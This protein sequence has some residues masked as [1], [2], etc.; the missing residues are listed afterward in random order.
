[1][2]PRGTVLPANRQAQGRVVTAQKG[3]PTQ[4]AGESSGSA[5][6][7]REYASFQSVKF[8]KPGSVPG[9]VCAFRLYSM[10]RV[11]S[12]PIFSFATLRKLL[13]NELLRGEEAYLEG[14][15]KWMPD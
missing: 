2:Q 10:E 8:D 13:S 6:R 5:N 14:C 4:V 1:M 11:P 12:A 3:E 15:W 9:C 7:G